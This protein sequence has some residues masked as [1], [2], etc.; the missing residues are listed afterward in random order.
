[1]I[2]VT[3][4]TLVTA[5]LWSAEAHAAT[6]QGNRTIQTLPSSQQVTCDVGPPAIIPP[7]AAAAGFTHCAANWDFSQPAYAALSNW[8]DADGSNPNVIWHAGSG[9]VTFC[10]PQTISQKHDPATGQ[11][12]ENFHWDV[13]YGNKCYSRTGIS[14]SNQIGGHT[15]NN[16]TKQPT[17]T[18][19]NYYLEASYRLEAPCPTCPSPGGG[20]PNAIYAG[21]VNQGSVEIDPGELYTN[22]PGYGQG[23]C[24]VNCIA[25]FIWTNWGA[26]QN[27]LPAGW[28][29][30]TYYKY[31][32][33]LTSD[34]ATNK[35]ECL[36]INDVL[37]GSGCQIVETS[38]F[39]GRNGFAI[40]AGSNNGASTMN[41]D[42]DVAYVRIWSCRSYRTAMCN[43]THLIQ[44]AIGLTYWH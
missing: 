31:S 3:I 20:G 22:T 42:L 44:G 14:Q 24:G 2:R 13:A 6:K 26:G 4:L 15:F 16:W 32:A 8:F 30:F 21:G 5:I 43:G 17:F 18:V 36:W 7:E 25:G 39:A 34:G 38:Q 12:V 35:Y 40:S 19:G 1:M 11:T 29:P 23:G 28:N 9:G 27:A 33:L 37:Q 10:N 41:I